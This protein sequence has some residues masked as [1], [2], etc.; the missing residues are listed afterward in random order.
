M[1]RLSELSKPIRQSESRTSSSVLSQYVMPGTQPRTRRT[2]QLKACR[3][4]PL[5]YYPLTPIEKLMVKSGFGGLGTCFVCGSFTPWKIHT[6]NLR[7]TGICRKCHSIN[8]HRS[9]AYVVCKS[10]SSEVGTRLRSLVDVAKLTNLK[11]YNTDAHSAVHDAL[12][13]MKNYVCSEYFGGEH[14]GGKCVNNVQHQDLMDLSF[15]DGSFDVV[16]SADVFEHIPSPYQAHREVYRVLKPGGRHIF[17][18]PFDQAQYLDDLRAVID[19]DGS[20]K[21]LKPPIYHHDPLRV[22][23]GCLVYSNFSIEMLVRLR[24]IGF[25][26]N[27]YRLQSPWHGIFGNNSTVFEAIKWDLPTE[28][29]S[30]DW[31]QGS[32]GPLL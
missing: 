3:S 22:D 31:F 26:T 25:R 28:L 11:V 4:Y 7:E 21:M 24:R 13:P 9:L 12:A 15:P 17:T 30:E 32:K 20:I 1:T 16:L 19:E 27:M 5:Y 23:E 6:D 8:R 10:L 14:A 2:D 18:V 29:P